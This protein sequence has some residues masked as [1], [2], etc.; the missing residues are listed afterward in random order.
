MVA[1]PKIWDILKKGV[2]QKLSKKS[3]VV[4]SIVH[5]GFAWR[6][7][8]VHRGMD[9][10]IFSFLFRKL[11][12]PVLGGRQKL[13]ATGGGPIASEVQSFV[14]TMFCCPLVQGYALTETCCAGT[15]QH[16]SDPR[17]GVVGPPA[18]SIEIILRDCVEPRKDKGGNVM[19]PTQYVPSVRDRNG[20]GYLR[21]D[22]SH[23]GEPCVG[24]GEVL[25]RGPSAI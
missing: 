9:S 5:F 12:V 21:S 23:Y 15:L 14:R 1:V 13:F 22:R 10:P 17:D 11:F 4:R 25:I 20:S 24:R 18:A 8:L 6:N 16:H 7:F 19:R 3:A 2:E